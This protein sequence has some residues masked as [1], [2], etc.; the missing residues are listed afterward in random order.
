MLQVRTLLRI[1]LDAGQLGLRQR[2]RGQPETDDLQRI[3]REPGRDQVRQRQRGL[4][5]R[6]PAVLEHHRD[7][8]VDA[9]RDGRRRPAL[10][11]HH[12]EVLDR[13]LHRRARAAPQYR[14]GHRPDHVEGL[15][16][17]V[18]PRSRRAGDLAGRARLA[19]VVLP[20]PPT[21]QIR[22]DGTQSRAPE[23]SQ[24]LRAQR[25]PFGIAADPALAA[26][27]AFEL[28]QPR[29][30]VGGRPPERTGDRVHVDIVERGAGV[31]L[32]ELIEQVVELADLLQRARRLAVA[33]RV[34][35]AHLLAPI[36]GQIGPQRT[37]ILRRARPSRCRA[38]RRAPAPSGSPA[39]PAAAATASASAARRP[40]PAGR[41]R[42][43][44][45]RRSADSPGRSR[46]AC[47]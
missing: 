29:H 3:L 17:A 19:Q 16:V 20:G 38:S 24:R 41:A 34:V 39:H 25:Q 6:P 46:R 35:A 13:Q 11:L 31:L 37:Q 43:S 8:Q 15:R 7:G 2:R 42:R 12:L 44:A 5:H 30:L 33:E 27:L 4:L 23:P 26:Q 18:L 14:S 22:E 1:G 36:P 28:L 9:E 32:A 40:P 10:G 21:A 45:R 47:S